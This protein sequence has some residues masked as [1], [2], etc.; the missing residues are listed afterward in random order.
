MKKQ[1]II[2]NRRWTFIVGEDISDK[3]DILI[4]KYLTED[5]YG[6]TIFSNKDFFNM[7]VNDDFDGIVLVKNIDENLHPKLQYELPKTFSAILP[8][9]RFVVTTNSPICIL[10]TPEKPIC[11]KVVRSNDKVKVERWDTKMDL[12]N[13]TPNLVLS[14]PLFDFQHII[15]RYH[16][17]G[18]NLR[19]E[20]M[21]DKMLRNKQEDEE[22]AKIDL[23]N[24]LF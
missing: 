10:G 24:K 17:D 20:D 12:E 5:V 22:I 23:P 15:P 11:L 1:N 7:P 18:L 4:A 19:T 9:A 21:Y 13:M 16:K 8:N 2:I 6:N 3:E 14:S